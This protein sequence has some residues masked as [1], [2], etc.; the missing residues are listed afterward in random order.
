[1]RDVIDLFIN[2]IFRVPHI[3]KRTTYRMA[4]VSFCLS[5]CQGI[6]EDNMVKFGTYTELGNLNFFKISRKQKILFR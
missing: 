5:V 4:L 6:L 1:M 2:I 3:K